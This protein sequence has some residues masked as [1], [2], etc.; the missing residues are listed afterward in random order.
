MMQQFRSDNAL[1]DQGN[2]LKT[3]LSEYYTFVAKN[4]R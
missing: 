3:E 1:K 2:W 4:S